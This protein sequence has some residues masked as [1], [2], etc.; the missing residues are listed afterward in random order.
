MVHA[1]IQNGHV[2]VQEPIPEAWEG[3]NVKIVPLTPDDPMPDLEARLAALHQLGPVELDAEERARMDDE[4]KT[5]DQI[6]KQALERIV[7]QPK[8]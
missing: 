5:L 8:P 6:S 4:L 7:D 2:E 3:Q 1:I